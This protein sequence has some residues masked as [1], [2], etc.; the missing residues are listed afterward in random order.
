[1]HSQYWEINQIDQKN[2]DLPTRMGFLMAPLDLL[3]VGA[4]CFLR[5]DLGVAAGL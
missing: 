5:T 1:M 4:F 2:R 3:G